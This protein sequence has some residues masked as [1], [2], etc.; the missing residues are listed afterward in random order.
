MAAAAAAP[1]FAVSCAN[2]AA[3]TG[4]FTQANVYGTPPS[5]YTWSAAG[6]T[7]ITLSLNTVADIG[8][9]LTPQNLTS[10]GGINQGYNG[11][12]DLSED[13]LLL[14]QSGSG[15]QRLT[16]TFSRPVTNLQF[17]IA[18]VDWL[19]SRYRDA[20]VLDPEPTS[21]TNGPPLQGNGTTGSPVS[22]V[23]A[24]EVTSDTVANRSRVTYAGPINSFTLYFSSTDGTTAQQIF[25]TG[26]TFFAC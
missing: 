10:A 16:I 7:P 17:T 25:L 18:D 19:R 2:P 9:S 22:A 6:R 26:L 4:R 14:Q 11:L 8:K 3:F 15:G 23:S 5:T 13:G 20:I 1:A 12:G 24:G 21:V